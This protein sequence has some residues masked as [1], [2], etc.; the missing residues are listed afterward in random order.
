MI[1][2]LRVFWCVLPIPE[3]AIAACLFLSVPLPSF[4]VSCLFLSVPLPLA[5]TLTSTSGQ[6]RADSLEIGVHG[7]ADY[8]HT[9]K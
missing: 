2:S 5:Y 6:L 4:G 9:E 3:C 7:G 1:C 8:L